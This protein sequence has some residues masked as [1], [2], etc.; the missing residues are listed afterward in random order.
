LSLYGKELVKEILFTDEKI[1][2]VEETYNKQND[3]VYA[4]SSKEPRQLVPRIK[5]GHY[6]ASVMLWWGVF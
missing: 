5:Q 1:F 3:R 2:T 6:L 4:Q